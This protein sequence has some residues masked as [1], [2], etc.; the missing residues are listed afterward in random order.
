M[1]RGQIRNITLETREVEE[2]GSDISKNLN[3]KVI[4]IEKLKK[5]GLVLHSDNEKLV[6]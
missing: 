6:N 4:E 2:E 1:L 3:S 5:E